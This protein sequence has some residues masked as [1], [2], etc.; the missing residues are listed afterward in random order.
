MSGTGADRDAEQDGTRRSASRDVVAEALR[1][2]IAL[3]GFEPGDRL[4][5]ERELAAAFGAGRNTVRQALRQLAEE[6]LVVTTLGR[7]GGT[8]V[9]PAAPVGAAGTGAQ[10]AVAADIRA[11]LRDYMEYRGAVEP[12]AARLAAERGSTR[13][14]RELVKLLDVGIGK[15]GA[16]VDI[17]AYHRVDS[18]FHLAVAAAGGNE[19]LH[20]AV[21]KARAEMFVGGNALWLHADWHVVYGADADLSCVFR[22]DHEGIALAVLAGDGATAEQR[23]REHLADSYQQFLRLL[24][25]FEGRG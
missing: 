23:M 21:A 22:D 7:N 8:R 11:T 6:G 25:H 20:E 10:A 2:R 13:A 1:K 12:L 3:G 19:V 15:A 14:R 18:R 24:D 16:A 9:A 5:T 4:P 17:S